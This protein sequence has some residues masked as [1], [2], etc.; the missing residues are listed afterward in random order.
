MDVRYKAN[1][2]PTS[3]FS[4]EQLHHI[5]V[6]PY[7]TVYLIYLLFP[8][9]RTFFNSSYLENFYCFFYQ[10]IDSF[11]D[12]LFWGDS[13]ISLFNT[14]FCGSKNNEISFSPR[15]TPHITA[16]CGRLMRLYLINSNSPPLVAVVVSCGVSSESPAKNDFK[17]ALTSQGTKKKVCY[18][19]DGEYFCWSTSNTLAVR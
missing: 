5:R 13:L 9:E 12:S 10:F 14:A 11:I 4:L 2:K 7:H 17:M 19:Y 1:R 3:L 6:F 8:F 16:P 18:Y 15:L